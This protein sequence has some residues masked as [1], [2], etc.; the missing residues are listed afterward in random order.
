MNIHFLTFKTSNSFFSMTANPI[1]PTVTMNIKM[2]CRAFLPLAGG[3]S[4]FY[5]TSAD[6]LPQITRTPFYIHGAA[7]ILPRAKQGA[8]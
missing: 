6:S 1:N 3:V 5:L 4:V 2:V 8:K 7:N